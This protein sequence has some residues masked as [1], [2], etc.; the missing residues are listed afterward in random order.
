MIKEAYCSKEVAKLLKEKGFNI[1]CNTAYYN[2]SLIDYTMYG[3][4]TMYSFDGALE[5]IYAPTHQMALQ[6]LRDEHKIFIEIVVSL[7]LNGKYH[8]SYNVLDSSIKYLRRGYTNFDWDYE[9]AVEDALNYVLN[10]VI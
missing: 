6:W 8:Y 2:D 4:Y 5:F 3:F 9:D 1:E 10:D 7:D